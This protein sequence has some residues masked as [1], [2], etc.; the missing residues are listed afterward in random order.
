MLQTV[1]QDIYLYMMNNFKITDYDNDEIPDEC[2]FR[3]SNIM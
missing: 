2:N 3:N 1:K